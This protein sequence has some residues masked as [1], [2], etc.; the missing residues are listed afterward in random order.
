MRTRTRRLR[1]RTR[2][3]TWTLFGRTLVSVVQV[4]TRHVWRRSASSGF[5]RSAVSVLSGHRES[6][7]LTS[8]TLAVVNL[9]SRRNRHLLSQCRSRPPGSA[10]RRSFTLLLLLAFPLLLLLLP[11]SPSGARTRLL[12]SRL[13][14][15][16]MAFFPLLLPP[17]LH[18]LMMVIHIQSP[19]RHSTV[20][21][22]KRY[23]SNRD[24]T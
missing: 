22:R 9:C 13:D 8:F 3:L 5:G 12:S 18:A 24:R 23:S 19:T 1:T 7:T 16:T 20:V 6:R 4:V 15:P 11:P 17:R 10:R 14:D 2:R 21:A